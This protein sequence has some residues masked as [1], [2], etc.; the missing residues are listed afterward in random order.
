MN[1]FPK[2]RKATHKFVVFSA[3]GRQDSHF[4][5]VYKSPNLSRFRRHHACQ[6]C[7]LAVS[8]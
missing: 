8:R 6:L 5:I 3:N 2:T 7:H 4:A 1:A